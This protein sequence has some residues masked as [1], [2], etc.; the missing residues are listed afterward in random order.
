MHSNPRLRGLFLSLD[1]VCG[2]GGGGVGGGGDGDGAGGDYRRRGCGDGAG[3]CNGET[4]RVVGLCG[5]AMLVA[6]L[7]AAAAYIAASCS[8]PTLQ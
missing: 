7:V 4:S 1:G 5:L 2:G 3:R 8:D 6:M